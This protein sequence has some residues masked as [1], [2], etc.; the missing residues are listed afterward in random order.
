MESILMQFH[1]MLTAG[2]HFLIRFT[3][4][5]GTHPKNRQMM[6][7][8]SKRVQLH[9][10][11]KSLQPALLDS[12]TLHTLVMEARLAA[13][14]TA[15][16][17]SVTKN[18]SRSTRL[19]QLQRVRLHSG[20]K[21]LQLALPDSQTLHTLVMEARLAASTTA[22]VESVT[23]NQSQSTRLAQLQRVPL[24]SGVKSLQLAL[25]D[26][27]ILHTPA[28][29]ARPAVSTTALVVFATSSFSDLTK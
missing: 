21:I 29:E 3:P 8:L 27:Q 22:Q 17:E 23:K 10:G 19:A 9:S 12:Q 6:H 7:V 25:L 11:V 16:V 2:W 1:S 28:M 24:H 26:S 15:Q 5:N 14:T 13:S 18:Q 20:V 4:P